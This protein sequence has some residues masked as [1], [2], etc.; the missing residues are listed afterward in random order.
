MSLGYWYTQSY[1]YSSWDRDNKIRGLDIE[2][3]EEEINKLKEAV[4]QLKEQR[5]DINRINVQDLIN[6]AQGL[7]LDTAWSALNPTPGKVVKTIKTVIDW[8]GYTVE[9]YDYAS[10]QSAIYKIDQDINGKEQRIDRLTSSLQE[11]HRYRDEI[12]RAYDDSQDKKRVIDTVMRQLR[13]L[14]SGYERLQDKKRDLE[15]R[16]RNAGMFERSGLESE[17]YR[18]ES[19]IFSQVR[20]VDD[21]RREVEQL[22]DNINSLKSKYYNMHWY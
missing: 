1:D 20:Q 16:I 8:A 9:I 19:D 10:Q 21:K 13:E 6:R 5:D 2:T 3:H 15:G 11:A 7:G 12:N 14:E 22:N 4:R 18:V 17:L